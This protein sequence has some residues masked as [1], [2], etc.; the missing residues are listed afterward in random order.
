M[1]KIQSLYLCDLNID[2]PFVVFSV[3][4]DEA[5][6]ACVLSTLQELD[7]EA[8]AEYELEV[9]AS[10]DVQSGSRAKRQGLRYTLYI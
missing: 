4:Y 10:Y 9:T 8:R 1:R 5:S 3:A 6:R 2:V 7:R